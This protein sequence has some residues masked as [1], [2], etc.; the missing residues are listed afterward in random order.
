M[1]QLTL[2]SPKQAIQLTAL[3]T[4]LHTLAQSDKSQV[5]TTPKLNTNMTMNGLILTLLIKP[6]EMCIIVGLHE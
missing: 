6:T 5:T 3:N 1:A 4:L 2:P